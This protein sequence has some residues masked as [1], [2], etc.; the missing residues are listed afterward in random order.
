[1]SDPV[2]KTTVGRIDLGPTEP[3]HMTQTEQRSKDAALRSSSTTI[4]DPEI[5][6]LKA[7][8]ERLRSWLREIGRNPVAPTPNAIEKMIAMSDA[9]VDTTAHT[10]DHTTAV[11]LAVDALNTALRQAHDAELEVSVKLILGGGRYKQIDASV[12][13]LSDFARELRNI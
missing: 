8:I 7:K 5:T 3:R 9:M 13:P 2:S 12:A 4:P 10:T 11:R 6:R 1:M